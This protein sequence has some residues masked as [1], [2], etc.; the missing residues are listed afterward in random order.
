MRISV[1]GVISFDH[2]GA[3]PWILRKAAA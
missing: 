2:S 3:P 1:A